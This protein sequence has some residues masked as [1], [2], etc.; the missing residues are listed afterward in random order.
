MLV[1]T[2]AP[3]TASA[4]ALQLLASWS[5]SADAATEPAAP[6]TAVG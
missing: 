6:T 4:D 5:A 3:G 1:Y 2:A